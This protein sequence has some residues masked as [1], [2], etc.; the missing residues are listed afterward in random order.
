MPRHV[1]LAGWLKHSG[2]SCGVGFETLWIF[3]K[4]GVL[5]GVYVLYISLL[6]LTC[7]NEEICCTLASSGCTKLSHFLFSSSLPIA[8]HLK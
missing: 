6:Y 7:L 4:I 8:G 2:A 1:F 3:R 5:V